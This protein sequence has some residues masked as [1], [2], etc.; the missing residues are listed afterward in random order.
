MF[1]I[2]H[3]KE[4][5]RNNINNPPVLEELYNEDSKEFSAAFSEIFNE[6]KDQPAAAFWKARLDTAVKRKKFKQLQIKD[7]ALLVLS[8]IIAGLLIHIPLLLGF[9]PASYQFYERNAAI[10]FFFGLTLYT[11]LTGPGISRKQLTVVV[12]LFLIPALYINML[13]SKPGSQSVTLAQIHL[14]LLMWCIYG[15]VCVNFNISSIKSRIEFIKHNGDMAIMGAITLIAGIAISV[16]TITMF[17][18]IDINLEALYSDYLVG[19]GLV[20]APVITLFVIKSFPGISSRIAPVMATVFTP[21]V[22]LVLIVFLASIPFSGLNPYSDRDFLLV[23]NIM[24]LAVTA[25]IVFAATETKGAEPRRFSLRV[26]FLTA[27]VA[28]IINIV[29]LSAIFYRL[30]EFGITPNRIAVLGSNI[31]VFINLILIARD[32]Y[33]ALFNN[34]LISRIEATTAEYLKYYLFWV[35]FVVFAFPLIFGME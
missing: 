25:L 16:M 9:E 29:A 20:S 35:L 21:V 22:L 7:I 17:S 6:I 28:L 13:P 30:G 3:M 33:R 11:L 26:L 27:T 1:N 5:I 18:V 23:F 4:Q 24:L 32:L 14:P 19:W 34:G 15:I 10:I 31:L 2:N 12:L 8:C